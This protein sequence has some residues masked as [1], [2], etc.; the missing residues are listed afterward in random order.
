M[1][2]GYEGF[3]TLGDIL[4]GG[5]GHRAEAKAPGYMKEAADGYSALDRAAILRAQ[6]IARDNLPAAIAGDPA[7]A[8]HGGLATAILGMATGQPNL[9]TYTG[10]L[11]DL[12]DIELDRQIQTKLEAG[13]LKGAQTLSAVK[14]DKVLPTLGAGGKAVFTPLGGDV[15]LTPLGESDLGAD[16][17]LIEQRQASA[18]KSNRPPA[19]KP[20]KHSP[21]A[22]RAATLDEDLGIIESEI[23][24]PLTPA[25][26][27]T[28]LQGGKIKLS[29]TSAPL[30][31]PE[32]STAIHP[33][34]PASR[35]FSQ[36]EVQQAINDAR[37]AISLGKLTKEQ[38]AQRLRDAGLDH[39]AG[40]L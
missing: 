39:A 35:A 20:I 31:E 8:T 27:A 4:T 14:T 6:R 32:P 29:D 26:R 40:R 16:A 34:K 12:G 10:G 15:E 24:R 13:D 17:A 33:H 19:E 7:M 23:G 30:G 21:I 5:P 36:D 38:A 1:P 28:Y 25:E 3:A 22:T 37:R 18:A 2:N 9:N 11:K